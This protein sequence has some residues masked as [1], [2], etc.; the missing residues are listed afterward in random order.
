MNNT[1]T[2]AVDLAK[3]VF[4]VCILSEHNKVIKSLRP[5]RD[6]FKEFLMRTEP[7]MIC[8]EACY[9]SY[10]WGRFAQD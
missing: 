8:M 3:S 7:S 1:N 2:I 10:Y 4:Q 5:S 6:K 9:S